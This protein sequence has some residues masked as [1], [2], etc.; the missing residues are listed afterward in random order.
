MSALKRKKDS[1]VNKTDSMTIRKTGSSYIIRNGKVTKIPLPA[2]SI[3]RPF[4]SIITG[5][6]PKKGTVALPG[7]QG[8]AAGKGAIVCP[9]VSVCQ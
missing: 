2:P 9:P 6:I 8:I 3:S 7:L 5:S 4:S 1:T